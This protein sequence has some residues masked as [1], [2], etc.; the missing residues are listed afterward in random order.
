MATMEILP[1]LTCDGCGVCCMHMSVPPYEF[2]E[3]EELQREHPEV[4]AD[5]K[6]VEESR[7][8]Q[9]KVHGTDFI[10]CGFFDM[11]TRKCR[12]NEHKPEVCQVFD[13]GGEYCMGMRQDA[14]LPVPQGA[15][16]A[17]PYCMGALVESGQALASTFCSMC[18]Y[19]YGSV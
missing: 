13:R 17:C 9:L 3:V 8:L 7:A 14:G 6:A 5:F 15:E 2:W 16:T 12:H 11:V 10:P 4:A 19:S 1:V 18:G